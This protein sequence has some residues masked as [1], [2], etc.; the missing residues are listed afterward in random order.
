[1][2]NLK[3]LVGAVGGLFGGYLLSNRSLRQQLK[4]AEDPSE[5]AAILKKEMQKSGKQ[6]AK[7]TQEWLQSPEVQLN[8][9]KAKDYLS[10][11]FDC[12]KGEVS[13]LADDASKRAKKKVNAS[14]KKAKKAVAGKR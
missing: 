6:V 1:M 12:A 7:E 8:W 4:E 13:H 11:Q 3:F 14:I 9:E 5:A 10:K 2:R